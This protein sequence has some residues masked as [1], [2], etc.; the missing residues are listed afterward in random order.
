MAEPSPGL[1]VT[2]QD[3]FFSRTDKFYLESLGFCVVDDPDAFAFIDGGSLVFNI[4]TPFHLSYRIS[5]GRHPLLMITNT[6]PESTGAT[7]EE[8][9]T[10]VAAML[11]QYKRDA[12][13]Q[14]CGDEY[15]EHGQRTS[16]YW[17]ERNKGKG[18]EISGP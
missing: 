16:V 4:S 12:F 6:D 2:F 17:R 18:K 5:Q 14:Y 15:G 8:G 11:S 3:P 7:E 9:A 13:I 1:P 10:A